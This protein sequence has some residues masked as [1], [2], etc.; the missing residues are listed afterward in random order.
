MST[1]IGS[2]E[3][4]KNRPE[5]AVTREN[6]IVMT[7]IAETSYSDILRLKIIFL[8]ARTIM[9]PM[10]HPATDMAMLE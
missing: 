9:A 6:N 4:D 10:K 3:F 1:L 8:V 2:V 7:V 5:V